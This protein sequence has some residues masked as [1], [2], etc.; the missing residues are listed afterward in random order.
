MDNPVSQTPAV[1][2]SPAALARARRFL[3]GNAAA[4]LRIGVRRTGCS[5]WGYEVALAEAERADD[6]VVEQDGVRLL[7]DAHSLALIRGTEVDFVRE[8]LNQQ[9]VF[10]NPNAVG[11][12]GCGESFTVEAP[13]PL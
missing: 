3:E 1:H 4:G 9:F 8:G 11:E 2:L 7:V 5:G 10:R 13:K 12:C 6:T